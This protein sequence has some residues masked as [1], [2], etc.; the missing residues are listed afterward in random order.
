MFLEDVFEDVFED[1]C[2]INDNAKP[3]SLP[4]Q[5]LITKISNIQ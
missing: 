4:E 2:K 1:V 5:E 3:I